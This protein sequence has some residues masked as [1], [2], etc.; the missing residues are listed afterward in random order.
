MS[1]SPTGEKGWNH[2]LAVAASDVSANT[3]PRT[4]HST[5]GTIGNG[6]L[7]PV[8]PG[9]PQSRFAGAGGGYGVVE[10]DGGH[11]NGQWQPPQQQQP[12]LPPKPLGSNRSGVGNA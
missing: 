10:L 5:V 9:S 8:S 3:S 6:V 7:S 4:Q 11:G 2:G 12:P 1:T